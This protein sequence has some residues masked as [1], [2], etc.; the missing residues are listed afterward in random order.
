MVRHDDIGPDLKLEVQS[1]AVKDFQEQFA[2]S[3]IGEDLGA[4]TTRE[5][6]AVCLSR[7]VKD[8]FSHDFSIVPKRNLFLQNRG[9]KG[10]TPATRPLPFRQ[11]TRRRS[12]LPVLSRGRLGARVTSHQVFRRLQASGASLTMPR[13]QNRN[14]ASRRNMTQ[15]MFEVKQNYEFA[16]ISVKIGMRPTTMRREGANGRERRHRKTC[17]KA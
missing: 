10:I 1:L 11:P 6:E 15:Q 13:S 2:E 9:A 5:R 3:R 7:R 16:R 17:R 4:S 12:R 14:G 8:F